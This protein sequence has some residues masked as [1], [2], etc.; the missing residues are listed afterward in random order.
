[1][2]EILISVSSVDRAQLAVNKE[3]FSGNSGGN[4]GNHRLSLQFAAPRSTVVGSSGRTFPMV[5]F[6]EVGVIY[7]EASNEVTKQGFHK[8]SET[9]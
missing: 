1:M 3:A 6:T 8:R 4:T 5:P 9:G 2:Y 7:A